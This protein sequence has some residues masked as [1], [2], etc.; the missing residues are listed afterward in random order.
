MINICLGLRHYHGY[1]TVVKCVL[2]SIWVFFSF[3]KIFKEKAEAGRAVGVEESK[4]CEMLNL[5]T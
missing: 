2:S 5:L 4:L 3:L 1:R